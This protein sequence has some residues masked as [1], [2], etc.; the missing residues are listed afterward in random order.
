MGFRCLGDLDLERLGD[1]D[2]GRLGDLVLECLGDL[3]LERLE[4][5]EADWF[6]DLD[7]DLDRRRFE[8]DEGMFST[9]Y[10]CY[11]RLFRFADL[12]QF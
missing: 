2:L 1:L 10:S 5:F 11:Y 3:D 4:D 7:L 8:L 9:I 12:S 6:S